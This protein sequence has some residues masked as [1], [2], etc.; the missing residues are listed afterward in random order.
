[1]KKLL[2][3]LFIPLFLGARTYID[4]GS[5][6]GTQNGAEQYPWHDWS[7]VT[8]SPGNTY[9][10]MGSS[11]Y[12]GELDMNNIDGN[13][14]AITT[15]NT[16]GNSNKATIVPRKT[17]TNAWTNYGDGRYGS[18]QTTYVSKFYWRT[19]AIA[20]AY[21]YGS[22]TARGNG[23]TTA[24]LSAGQYFYGTFTDTLFW[25]PN[26]GAGEP[27]PG[28]AGSS[29]YYTFQDDHMCFDIKGSN[30]WKVDNYIFAWAPVHGIYVDANCMY[31]SITNS[32]ALWN[33]HVYSLYRDGS[34]SNVASGDEGNGI[35]MEGDNFLVDH[36]EAYSNID[37]GITNENIAGADKPV[38]NIYQ[39]CYAHDNRDHGMTNRGSNDADTIADISQCQMLYNRI[40]HNGYDGD[41]GSFGIRWH[42]AQG[43]ITGNIIWDNAGCAIKIPLP[44]TSG[45]I[46]NV[47]NLRTDIFNNL[48]YHNA[49]V[50]TDETNQHTITMYNWSPATNRN[51][52][53]MWN[54]TIIGTNSAIRQY[55]NS[56]VNGNQMFDMRNNIIRSDDFCIELYLNPATN[57]GT[58]TNNN[59]MPITT[60]QIISVNASA[61]QY[62]TSTIGTW[63]GLS[64]VGTDVHF[65]TPTVA[66]VNPDIGSYTV[67]GTST[68]IDAG[69]NRTLTIL[70]KDLVEYT[71]DATPDIGAYE[72]QPAASPTPTPTPAAP[73]LNTSIK[74]GNS[75][76]ICDVSSNVGTDT[77]S[78]I[79]LR[80]GSQSTAGHA[81]GEGFQMVH[82]INYGTD[83]TNVYLC[84][85]TGGVWVSEDGGSNW[86]ARH[87]G[88]TPNGGVSIV[89]DPNNGDV[90]FVAASRQAS[91]DLTTAQDGIWYSLDAG[92]NWTFAENHEYYRRKYGNAFVFTSPSG[93][94]SQTIYATTHLDGVLRS[95]DGG[96][97]W[98]N[99]ALTGTEC[100]CLA[101]NHISGS[102]TVR[103]YVGIGT[104]TT[105]NLYKVQDRNGSVVN[106]EIGGLISSA[107]PR[108]LTVVPH[109]TDPSLDT[110]YAACGTAG[111]YKSTN[112]GT[113]FS[114]IN[115]GLSI[116][117]SN[118]YNNVVV[119][120]ANTSYLFCRNRTAG[121]TDNPYWSTNGGT[122]WNPNTDIDYGN[123][124]TRLANSF[125]AAQV[126]DG[127]N[128]APHPTASGTAFVYGCNT[129]MKTTNAGGTWTY[130]GS[131]YIAGRRQNGI[132]SSWFNASN[133][134]HYILGLVD[135]G[136]CQTTDG[137]STF[138]IIEPN[139]S[140]G[141]NSVAC[142]VVDPNDTNHII[143]S[144]KTGVTG[145]AQILVTTSNGGSSWDEVAGVSDSEDYYF[146]AYSK[147]DSNDIYIAG[148]TRS[149]YSTNNGTSWAT[150]TA[151]GVMRA[152]APDNGNT[153]L[154][155]GTATT[156]MYASDNN[157]SSWSDLGAYPVTF[158]NLESC[159]SAATRTVW[160]CG[161]TGVHRYKHGVWHNM[162]NNIA[163]DTVWASNNA[164]SVAVDYEN[165]ATVYLGFWATA[166]GKRTEYIFKSLNA[167]NEDA[168]SVTWNNIR[169]NLDTCGKVWGMSINPHDDQ[170]YIS[171]DHGNYKL[172]IPTVNIRRTIN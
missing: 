18:S 77:W 123:L 30:Y 113:T 159:D 168:E 17:W 109:A 132:Y 105:H 130:S 84:N 37:N 57:G 56:G 69:D 116:S 51:L 111:V 61:N 40:Y 115:S 4:P 162:N 25:R 43:S 29:F 88:Y 35:H 13:S 114:T 72:F 14:G 63:N 68:M 165:T 50:D 91:T 34:A 39:Y 76:A 73:S 70:P 149:W 166:G 133:P 81:G 139:L 24:L 164:I 83:G 158:A 31:G 82:S 127:S 157:G 118:E 100:A 15:F 103:L 16:Y 170:P 144:F 8:I 163:T 49:T 140:N 87:K 54:N 155:F 3:I 86:I 52:I 145:A 74:Q 21:P 128:I 151:Q 107:F 46:M 160:I 79:P 60:G 32:I 12:I 131:G 156:S 65:G 26:T 110:V 138:D 119:S 2:L 101:M 104:V 59:Y 20:G 147:T 89:P 85:D 99:I 44:Y 112:G 106:E 152:V 42:N 98:G 161:N 102:T 64:Y 143:T 66:F 19:A 169:Q 148:D 11:T 171:T 41:Y 97:T 172:S 134:L 22:E 5:G 142:F 93:G 71:R 67:M 94:R 27:A 95:T 78:L 136:L 53:R 33:G 141:Q 167:N 38:G 7:S 126:T 23:T 55:S 153:V 48:M 135:H 124:S 108:T 146:M 137:G 90:V 122:S 75:R 125:N 62:G 58:F 80:T 36:C 28:D 47:G 45:N 1:M 10:Q 96:T 120:P 9:S 6:T 121:D 129:M 117:A 150:S 92:Q 154:A